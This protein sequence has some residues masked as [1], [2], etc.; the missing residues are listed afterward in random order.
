MKRSFI[1]WFPSAII[2]PWLLIKNFISGASISSIISPTIS[3]IISSKDNNPKSSPYSST[4]KDKCS[5]LFLNSTSWSKR[6]FDDGT[7]QGF[8]I[9]SN[10]IFLLFWW[11]L[12]SIFKDLIFN[13]PIIFLWV[14]CRLYI[15][16]NYY[17]D[18]QY[19]LLYVQ[20]LMIN[21]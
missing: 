5:F 15:L 6:F 2:L 19:N 7:N 21:D 8:V 18:R 1:F 11:F 13:N 12:I 9:L 20:W 10:M 4:T 17:L 16:L 14:Y 3:S